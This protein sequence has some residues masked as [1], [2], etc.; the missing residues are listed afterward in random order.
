MYRPWL[1][2]IAAFILLMGVP[3]GCSTPSTADSPPGMRY[4]Q[5]SLLAVEPA[6]MDKVW[7]ASRAALS[8]LDITELEAQ[9]STL[10]AYIDGRTPD[11]KKVSVKM[12]PLSGTKTELKIRIG[13]F[14]DE[15]LA[16]LI[17]EKIQIALAP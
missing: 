10:A 15:S 17:Y 8:S 11:L 7:R 13:T 9:G 16:R 5:G 2:T 4:S 3:T 1:P 6:P 12:R 14:G